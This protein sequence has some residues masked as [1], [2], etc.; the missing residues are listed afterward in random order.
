LNWL[1]IRVN[2]N[3]VRYEDDGLL[4]EIIQDERK[5][6]VWVGGWNYS[7]LYCATENRRKLMEQLKKIEPIYHNEGLYMYVAKNT[8]YI[9]WIVE[10]SLILEP[11]YIEH[12]IIP[13]RNYVVE[14][15]D[16]SGMLVSPLKKEDIKVDDN[17][18]INGIKLTNMSWEYKKEEYKEYFE[19]RLLPM[20]MSI[21]NIVFN[22]GK[23]DILLESPLGEDDEKRYYLQEEVLIT[24]ESGIEAVRFADEGYRTLSGPT[25]YDAKKKEFTGRYMFKV[26][27]SEFIRWLEE[28]RGRE[29]EDEVNHYFIL[30]S[31]LVVDVIA[32]SEP[33]IKKIGIRRITK[34]R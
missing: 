6:Y 19:D 34:K 4:I 33:K 11:D 31:M 23:L 3:A 32:K 10:D 12:Y 7:V 2:C 9:E 26:E 29:F 24:F 17:K 22:K 21:T 5:F 30:S 28:E 16:V 8:G 14:Y 13:T 18:I 20:Y 1:N 15:L 27:N 25:V